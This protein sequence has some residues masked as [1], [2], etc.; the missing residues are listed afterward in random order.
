MVAGGLADSTTNYYIDFPVAEKYLSELRSSGFLSDFF[1]SDLM[2]FFKRCNVYL[3]KHPQNDGPPPGLDAD[4]IMKRQDYQDIWDS[5]GKAKSI[6][7]VITQ[8]TSVIHLSFN[9]YSHEKYYLSKSGN[10]W[11]ID[12]IGSSFKTNAYYSLQ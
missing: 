8:N 9:K 4:L 1:L 2:D 3:K 12:S 7:K 11:L 5:L 10:Q 6:E